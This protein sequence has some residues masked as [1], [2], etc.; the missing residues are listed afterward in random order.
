M[1][2]DCAAFIKYVTGIEKRKRF[3]GEGSTSCEQRQQLDQLKLNAASLIASIQESPDDY[4]G[5][6]YTHDLLTTTEETAAL[7]GRFEPSA[8]IRVL[9]VQDKDQ[10]AVL[11]S[12]APF[13]SVESKGSDTLWLLRPDR[14]AGGLRRPIWGERLGGALARAEPAR[15]A[16]GGV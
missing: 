4:V 11:G 15:R 16:A 6:S 1:R 8:V 3:S 10:V 2:E 13:C 5:T 12:L 14:R 9:Q 7:S